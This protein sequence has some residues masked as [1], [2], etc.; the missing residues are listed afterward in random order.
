MAIKLDILRDNKNTDAY[1]KFSYADLKLDLELNSHIPS[2]PVGV[3]KNAADLKISYDM[4]NYKYRN[5]YIYNKKSKLELYNIESYLDILYNWNKFIKETNKHTQDILY[6]TIYKQKD[7]P[8]R[9]NIDN[10]MSNYYINND[11]FFLA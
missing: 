5:Y 7:R 4:N 9:N 8:K 2:A 3:P 10:N 6:F 1:R 11:S